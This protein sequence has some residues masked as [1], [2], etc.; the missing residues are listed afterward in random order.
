MDKQQSS[1]GLAECNNRVLPK[2][3]DDKKITSATDDVTKS[4][5]ALSNKNDIKKNIKNN[6]HEESQKNSINE[7]EKTD[8]P[9][10][11]PVIEQS[12]RFFIFYLCKK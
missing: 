1:Q 6:N 5:I 10:K 3:I 12:V 9:K 4:A 11:V 8:Q 2:K 7:K